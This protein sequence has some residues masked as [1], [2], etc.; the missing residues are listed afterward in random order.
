MYFLFN[1]AA[2]SSSFPSEVLNATVITIYKPGKEST[3]PKNFRPILLLNLDIKIHAK[4]IANR[5]VDILPSLIHNDQTGFTKGRQSSDT[6]RRLI[7]IIHMAETTGKPSLLLFLDAEK[8]FDRVH[9]KYL[10]SVLNKFGF[11]GTILKA[12]MALYTSS[13]AWVFTSDI[14]STPFT[15]TNGTRQG[16]PLSP[17]IFN[18]MMEPL[19]D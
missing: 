17:L 15:I 7:N 8:V 4:L 12:I 16:C 18:L 2:S 9:W 10:H 5:L 11:Q 14:M 13:S 6:T 19:A 3:S 1:N